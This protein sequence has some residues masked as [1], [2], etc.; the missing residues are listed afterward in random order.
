[1]KCGK[2]FNPDNREANNQRKP[3]NTTIHTNTI[4]QKRYCP[5]RQVYIMH[6]ELIHKKVLCKF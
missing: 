2:P 4:F 3:L 6:E 1:M 5:I